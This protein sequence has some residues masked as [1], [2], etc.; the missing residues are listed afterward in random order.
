MVASVVSLFLVAA[1]SPTPTPI[2]GA[3]VLT[4][5]SESQGIHSEYGYIASQKC[6]QHGSWKVTMQSLVTANGRTYDK[7]D[8]VCTKGNSKRSFLFDITSFFGKP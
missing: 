5:H 2:P 4:A 7:L 6:G 8:A 1:L 3:I